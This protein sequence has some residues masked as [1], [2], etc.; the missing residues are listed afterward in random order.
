MSDGGAG[1][2]AAPVA[3][4]GSAQ[5]A[6]ELPTVQ[7]PAPYSPL[8]TAGDTAP[9]LREDQIANAVSFLSHDKVREP[10]CFLRVQRVITTSWKCPACISAYGTRS[11]S[12]LHR[13]W[14]CCS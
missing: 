9:P 12:S 2:A 3:G 5:E 10:H 11:D 14:C 13:K 4:A 8:P 1:D 7:P 6:A